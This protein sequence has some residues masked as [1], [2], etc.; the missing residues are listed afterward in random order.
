MSSSTSA[1]AG[2]NP[3][4]DNTAAGK[5]IVYDPILTTLYKDGLIPP[6]FSLAISRDI[7]GPSGYLALGGL[8]P[9]P[10]VPLFTSTPILITTI[11]GYPKT[12]DFYTININGVVLNGKSLPGSGGNIQY[13]VDSGTTLNYFPTAVSNAVNA[14]FVPPAVYSDEEGAYVVDCKAK[15]PSMGIKISGTTFWTNHLD[16]ILLAGTDA[17]GTD[18]CISGITDGGSDTASDLYILGDTFQ[19]NVVSVFDVGAVEMRF[20]PREFYPSNDPY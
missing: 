12:Y 17:N 11:Q 14:A 1:Y 10:F 9:V 19:K 8:P 4:V 20:A 3:S 18:I 6:L 2:S 13:I 16:M 15:A 5:Q 7:S